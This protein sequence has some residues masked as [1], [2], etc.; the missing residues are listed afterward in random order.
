MLKVI[1]SISRVTGPLVEAKDVK[2]AQMLE[3]VEVGEDHLVG[4][5]VHLEKDRCA[6]QVYEETTGLRP[7][8]NVYGSGMPLSVELGPGLIG[9]IYDGIQRPLEVIRDRSDQYAIQKGIHLPPLDRDKEWAFY[10]K[11]KKGEEVSGGTILGVV[12]ETALIEHRVMVP[13]NT[14][15]VVKKIVSEGKYHLEDTIAVL[16]PSQGKEVILNMYQRWPVRHRRIFKERSDI[17][18]PLITGQRVIDTLFPVTK[19]GTVTV[20]GGFGTGK[21]MC[22]DTPIMLGDGSLIP[23]KDVFQAHHGKGKVTRARDEEYTELDEPLEV[24]SFEGGKFKRK[25]ATVVYMGKT[26]Y[27]VKI[28][29]RTGREVEV[30]PVHKL[31]IMTPEMKIIEKEACKIKEG[32]FIISPRKLP[33]LKNN[34]ELNLTIDNMRVGKEEADKIQAI[35]MEFSRKKELK[36]L[37]KVL[38]EAYHNV[39]GYRIGRNRPKVKFVYKLQDLMK[40][41]ISIN[42]IKAERESREVKLPKK[43]TSE[44]AEFLGF[45]LSDGSV[46]N[47]SIFFYNTDK[48]LRARFS[49]L[50]YNLFGLETGEKYART[51]ES[52]Y[53]Y[54]I[55]LTKI[56]QELG[57]PLSKKSI[58]ARIPD[59]ILISNEKTIAS[60]LGA[61]FLCDGSISGYELEITTASKKM[62]SQLSYLFTRCGVLSKSN[63]KRVKDSLYYRLFV[64]GAKELRTFLVTCKIFTH[65]KFSII[66]NYLSQERRK[67][68]GVD[69]VP[70]GSRY[71]YEKFKGSG[72]RRQDFKEK[73]I[74]LANYTT[75]L[76]NMS[77]YLFKEFAKLIGDPQ[78]L[79]LT[80]N[81]LEH[82][83]CD[84]VT[85]KKVQNGNKVVYDLVVPGSHNLVGG[86]NPLILHNTMV[87]HQLAKWCDADLIV[88]IGCGERGN[89]MTDVLTNFP[90]LK[91]PRTGRPLMERTIFVANTSNMPVAAREASIYTGITMAEYYRDMGY[92]VS[93]MADSTSRWAE[94]LRELS[95]RMEEMPADEGFPAYLP[96]RLAEFYERAGMVETLSG[97]QGSV[98]I[99]ASVSPPGGDFSEPVTQHTKR[100][101]RCFWALDR[102]LANARHYPSISWLDSYSEYLDEI[103][104]WWEENV[105]SD[106]VSLRNE[107]VELLQKEG[108]LQQV[109]K[110]VGPDVLPDSQRLVLE[111]CNMFKNSFLQQNAFD[112]ID[113]FTVAQKQV[114]MLRVILA[115]YHKGLQA[116]KK[117]ALLM[118]LRK[119][120]VYPKIIRM[121]FTIPN[122]ELG[123][124]DDLIMRAEKQIETLS[125]QG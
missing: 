104:G 10:P 75:Q 69:I 67:F 122:D 40:I 117:G 18:V 96:T 110:L 106:W 41:N 11:V 6:I 64:S 52:V 66:E 100:F 36:E 47:N 55:V 24:M 35:L 57:F 44:F 43:V 118:Q 119:L 5:I 50:V 77:L 46:I 7:G 22:G 58:N 12:K 90:K 33:N 8:A 74:K 2:D 105:D 107:I 81:E 26:N 97:K 114:K 68:K 53:V 115:F 23:I 16:Q 93:V 94:A 103:S 37:S 125:K 48:N 13:P 25:R 78:L 84:K 82:V 63:K 91:D 29:T 123:K 108:K 61:Y 124:L 109:V 88:F 85:K 83:F 116:I 39:I 73:G 70:A 34:P 56:L 49:E 87:Q 42:K 65:K 120:A 95:G 17:S 28:E 76:E 101:V 27:T 113:S 62:S 14:G 51:V 54:S 99:I 4:E 80:Q 21:C 59:C 3:L 9:T 15:G 31:H 38:G 86:K 121:K 30:T 92:H 89:E 60:F 19:G 111:V 32:D 112:K 102:E 71:I 79:N 72:K 45:L 98:S 20:P 1:G